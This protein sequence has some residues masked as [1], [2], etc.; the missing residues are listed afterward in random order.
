MTAPLVEFPFASQRTDAP[1]L[2]GWVA[3]AVFRT[4]VSKI[5]AAGGEVLFEYEHPEF[6]Y[7][8][9]VDGSGKRRAYWGSMG[10]FVSD[11][12]FLEQLGAT[13]T[14]ITSEDAWDGS[15]ESGKFLT[16]CKVV[17]YKAHYSYYDFGC[18]GHSERTTE[19]G[20]EELA[21]ELLDRDGASVLRWV[22]G[23]IKKQAYLERAERYGAEAV[24]YDLNP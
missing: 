22:E 2:Q 8:Y 9:L 5:M 13:T 11:C 14:S 20:E 19:F 17:H 18:C 12:V 6:S 23:M 3:T 1:L 4:K 10:N 16:G 7:A 21:L 15:Q 24:V